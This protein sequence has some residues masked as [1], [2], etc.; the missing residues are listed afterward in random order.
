MQANSAPICIGSFP[1]KD[2]EKITRYLLK[3]FQEF[4]L[5][6][7]LPN[8]AFL[9]SMYT[10]YSEGMPLTDIDEEKK[11]IVF[12]NIEEDNGELED[13]FNNIEKKNYEA[14]AITEKYAKGLHTFFRLAHAYKNFSPLAVKGH[15]TGPISFALTV[16]DRNKKAVY[17]D[18]TLLE[19]V[20]LT[21]TMKAIWQIDFLKNLN[22]NIVLF[23]DE[24]YLSGIGSGM[25]AVEMQDAIN[26]IKNFIKSIKSVYP[27]VK[28]AVHCCGNTD[29]SLVFQTELDILSFDAFNFGEN[30]LFYSEELKRFIEDGGSIAWGIVPTSGG[31]L[32]A[33]EDKIQEK[34]D[35]ILVS[36]EQ[37]GLK[38]EK[39]LTSSFFSPACGTGS[40][41]EE[42]S[43]KVL[44][45]L[46][47]ISRFYQKTLK[48]IK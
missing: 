13:F 5:W 45:L 2:P 36:L 26:I 39:V 16:T 34:F 24:P 7:Q 25:L 35:K 37:K 31:F 42:E 33:T 28:L 47:N 15:I 21:L 32:E 19:I 1:H 18:P 12:K 23:I 3:T 8:R 11:T 46:S 30:L 38:K 17:F 29:W 9:E 43:Q 40:L 27:D 48:S 6:P 10:Q 41:K 22:N 44:T 14:F 4:P 20:T